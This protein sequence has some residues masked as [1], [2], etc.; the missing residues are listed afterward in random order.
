MIVKITWLYMSRTYI[1]GL[2]AERANSTAH[3]IWTSKDGSKD[4]RQMVVRFPVATFGL[5]TQNGRSKG[6]SALE[7]SSEAAGIVLIYMFDIEVCIH[8]T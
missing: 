3:N 8:N 2:N 1:T 6:T 7:L 5:C 4:S